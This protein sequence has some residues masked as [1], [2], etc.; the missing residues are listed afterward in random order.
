MIGLLIQ[1][2]CHIC[3]QKEAFTTYELLMGKTIVVVGNKHTN[4][5]G[6][7]IVE[8]ESAYQGNKFLLKLKNVLYIPSNQNN[9][10]SLR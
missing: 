3:N 9:L 4:I 1:H 5:E 2:P 10:I 7:G 8:L 6:H